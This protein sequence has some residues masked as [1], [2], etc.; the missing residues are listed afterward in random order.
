MVEMKHIPLALVL[1]GSSVAVAQPAGAPAGYQP[2]APDSGVVA[3]TQDPL[4][5]PGFSILDRGDAT[6]KAG[7]ELS[8]LLLGDSAEGTALRFD[9][10]GQFVDRASGFGGYVQ[11]PM[12]LLSGDSDSNFELSGVE[13]G[14]LLAKQLSPEMG[15][16]VRAGVVLPTAQDDFGALIQ[17]AITGYARPSDIVNASPNTIIRLSG[18]PMFR[19]GQLFG[20]I[21]I[22]LDFLADSDDGDN[23]ALLRIGPGIGFDGGSFALTGELVTMRSI[24][25]DSE[26]D[27]F[28]TFAAISA[29]MATGTTAPYVAVVLPVDDRVRDFF[30]AAIT[31]GVEA[32]L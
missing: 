19:S 8:Y 11:L 28:I 12:S 22:G 13:L 14:G 32:A 31:L 15:I 27:D 1:L 18:S 24:G 4:R 29:R 9:L 23:S 20:R 17:N 10:H 6:S 21:D 3:G 30:N 16:V 26:D 7:G 2:Y 25:G 5:S